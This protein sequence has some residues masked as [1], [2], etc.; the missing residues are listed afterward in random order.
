ITKHDDV[1]AISTQPDRFVSA[2]RWALIPEKVEQR[3]EQR[4]P[5]SAA[6]GGSPMRSLINMDPPDHRSHRSL[7]SPFFR[8]RTLRR[9]EDH[10]RSVTRALLDRYSGDGVE[11]EFVSDIAEWHPLRLILEILGLG[12]EHADLVVRFTGQLFAPDD[13]EVASEDNSQLFVEL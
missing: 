7:A 8:P 2:P 10:M 3:T 1:R 4:Y 12:T 11:L 9:I 13:E 5:G 6:R